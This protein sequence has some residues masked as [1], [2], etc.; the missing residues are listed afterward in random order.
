[1]ARTSA[2]MLQI[3][4]GDPRSISR[5]IVDGVRMKVATAELA[6]GARNPSRIRNSVDL[7]APL[8]PTMAW[9]RPRGTCRVSASSASL[10]P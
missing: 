1:M 7:P 8:A 5:Q 9:M 3:A 10:R 2:L 6:V 4:T